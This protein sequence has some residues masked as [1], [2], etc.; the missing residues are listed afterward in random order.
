[1]IKKITYKNISIRFDDGG[2]GTPV[3]LLHGYLESLHIWDDL[4]CPFSEKYRV[5]SI[6]LPGHGETGIIGDTSSMEF[7]AEVVKEVLDHLKID[8][9]IFFGHSMGG[10]AALAFLELF[11]E[12]LIGFSLF[13]SKPQPDPPAAIENRK[14][15]INLVNEGKKELVVNTNVP[16][17]FAD[18]NLEKFKKEIEYAKQIGRKTP[19]EGIKAALK[20]MMERPSRE[21]ILMNTNFPVLLILGKQDNYIPFVTMYEQIKI[22]KKGIH[23]ILEKSGHMGFIEEKEKSL[24]GV[25]SFIESC[26]VNFNAK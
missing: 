8:K 20:G 21:D 13:H 22:P 10:Y 9:C 26:K 4:A 16:M 3:V 24:E 11:P 25:M 19:N 23:L 1:M 15:G 5:I 14:R 6:D 7:M 2:E 18:A 17:A 12:R